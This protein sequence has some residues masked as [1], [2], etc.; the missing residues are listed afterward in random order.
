MSYDNTGG[1]VFSVRTVDNREV[2]SLFGEQVRAD[3]C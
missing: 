1:V 3:S 2:I